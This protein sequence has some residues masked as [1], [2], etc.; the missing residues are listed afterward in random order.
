MCYAYYMTEEIKEEVTKEEEVIIEEVKEKKKSGA[1]GF[2]QKKD[3]DYKEKY[4][5]A[6]ADYQNLLKRTADEKQEFFKYANER[7][8]MEI[9]PVYV[10]LKIS[11]EHVDETAT[12]SGW[13]EGVKYIVKQFTDVLASL[14]V[15]EIKI[16]GE[17]FDP[18]TMDALEGEGVLVA[19]VVQ[20]GY[21]YKGKVLMA[22]KVI[23]K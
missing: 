15:E 18:A 11:L 21:V 9:L 14:G 5:R 13:G 7:M 12:K 2:G 3:K 10:N 19:K 23:L 16:E 6:L 4:L 17:A 1:F 8:I 20:A 22:A